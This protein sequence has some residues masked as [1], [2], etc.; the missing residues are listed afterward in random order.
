LLSVRSRRVK[1]TTC[2]GLR[3]TPEPFGSIQN[4]LGVKLQA[5]RVI[6]VFRYRNR[7]MVGQVRPNFP[8]LFTGFRSV[9]FPL[10]GVLT[11]VVGLTTLFSI[12]VRRCRPAASSVWMLPLLLEAEQYSPTLCRVPVGDAPSCEGAFRLSPV[13][14]SSISRFPSAVFQPRGVS[15]PH[16]PGES[17]GLITCRML[18]SA[19]YPC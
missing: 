4:P 16:R 2:C 8:L 5:P 13:R 6:A 17:F 3:V 9:C 19:Y 14:L 1:S 12:T 7:F 18:R 10:A 11:V 15:G